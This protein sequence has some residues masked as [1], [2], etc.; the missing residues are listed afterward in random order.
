MTF[1]ELK[2]EARRQGYTLQRSQRGTCRCV[3]AREIREKDPRFKLRCCSRY[4]Y[5]RT[6]AQGYTVC[7]RK[8]YHEQDKQRT[9]QP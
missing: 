6:T 7:R 3:I 2:E 4:E 9:A 8:E 1:E 5:E